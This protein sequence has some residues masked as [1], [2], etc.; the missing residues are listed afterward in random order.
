METSRQYVSLSPIRSCRIIN[1]RLAHQANILVDGGGGARIAGLG[2]ATIL[3]HSEAWTMVEGETSA[4]RLARGHTP[5]PTWGGPP[6]N[7]TDTTHPTTA[8]DILALGVVSWE[9]WSVTL[10]GYVPFS[11]SGQV[12]TGRVPFCEMTKAAA[13]HSM[14]KGV[15]P[16]RPNGHRISD[17]MWYIIEHCWHSEPSERISI[18]EAVSLLETELGHA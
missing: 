9:V 18:E 3:P 5:E 1:F 10:G 13:S 16:Q 15:R 8:D 6:S 17:R 7:P 4:D 11:H 2:N 12:L 14:L